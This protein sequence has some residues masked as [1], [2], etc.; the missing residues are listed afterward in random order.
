MQECPEFRAQNANHET[1]AT[2]AQQAPPSSAPPPSPPIKSDP[3]LDRQFIDTAQAAH[4][5]ASLSSGVDRTGD[6]IN[7]LL[8]NAEPTVISL[9]AQS[10]P[11][12]IENG[13]AALKSEDLVALQAMRARIDQLLG[14]HA[15]MASKPASPKPV[16]VDAEVTMED[17]PASS[18]GEADANEGNEEMSLVTDN[19]DSDMNEDEEPPAI[20]TP[21]ASITVAGEPAA[22]CEGVVESEWAPT[23][24]S[25]GKEDV[26]ASFPHQHHL[27]PVHIDS[28]KPDLDDATAAPL[29]TSILADQAATKQ[30]TLPSPLTPPATSDVAVDD[31]E[32]N[33]EDEDENPHPAAPADAAAVEEEL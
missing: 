15:A 1:V 32:E 2:L 4:G 31:E 25:T 33:D 5:L 9:M 19:G 12:N 18:Q 27:R 11:L 7:A 13:P 22:A 28:P 24:I 23:G 14:N 6:L 8:Q 20:A 26:T 3:L 16:D 30:A 21:S 17:A 29:D 10:S